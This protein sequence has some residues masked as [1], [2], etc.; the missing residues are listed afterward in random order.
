MPSQPLWAYER[1]ALWAMDLDGKRPGPMRTQTSARFSEAKPETALA[2]AAAMNLAEPHIVQRRFTAG[3]RCF[4]ARIDGA[5]AGYGWISQGVEH[6]GELERELRMRP[7]E[8]YIWDCAT[9]PLFRRQGIYSALLEY[10]A[11]ALRDEGIRR[12]WIGASLK[13]RPSLRGFANAGFQPAITIIYIRLLSVSHSWLIGE[14]SAPPALVAD[15][16]GT[17][18][19]VRERAGATTP[20]R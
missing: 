9:L 6:I 8:A 16:R 14:A 20:A 17:L 7:D 15:A 18:I 10:I 5:I 12:L 1:G 2:L 11:A 19:D 3:S 4:V 13:N